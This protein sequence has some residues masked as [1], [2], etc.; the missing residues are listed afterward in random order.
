MK[1]QRPS[2]KRRSGNGELN[3]TERDESIA[4]AESIPIYEAKKIL[5]KRR[6]L[7]SVEAM[8]QYSTE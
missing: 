6:K 5:V 1:D 7:Q 2:R 3:F 8:G 4:A